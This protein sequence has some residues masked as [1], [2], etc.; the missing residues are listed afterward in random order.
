MHTTL[1]ADLK[2]A[3]TSESDNI[4]L[5]NHMYGLLPTMY[6]RYPDLAD[7]YTI[8]STSKDRNGTVYVSTMEGKK[9]PFTGEGCLDLVYTRLKLDESLRQA[10]MS[11]Y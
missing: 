7:W 11:D 1:Q 10:C 4:V 9:Y 6:T 3:L 8:T 5:Q 2:R